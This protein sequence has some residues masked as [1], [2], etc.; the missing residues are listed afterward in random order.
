MANHSDG[1]AI[2]EQYRIFTQN[3]FK[4]SYLINFLQQISSN[5]K[6]IYYSPLM[7]IS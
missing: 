5:D 7:F 4:L 3:Q 1:T 6:P 2:K